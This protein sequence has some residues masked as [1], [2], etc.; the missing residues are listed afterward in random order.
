M[1]YPC[2]RCNKCGNMVQLDLDDFVQ[3]LR[4]DNI[5]APTSLK[6]KSVPITDAVSHL[7]KDMRKTSYIKSIGK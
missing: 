7:S 3:N 1:C 5:D 4:Q 2:V 6:S